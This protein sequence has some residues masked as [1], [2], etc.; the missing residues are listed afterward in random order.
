MSDDEHRYDTEVQ[1]DNKLGHTL[2]LLVPA[3]AGGRPRRGAPRH[4]LRLRAHRR[5]AGRPHGLEYIGIDAFPEGLED[6]ARRGFEGHQ[7]DLSVPTATDTL[8][9]VLDGR[10]LVSVSSSTGWST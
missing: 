2:E 4:R 9:K 3:P 10:R 6:L 7:V 8:I 5:A 1:P